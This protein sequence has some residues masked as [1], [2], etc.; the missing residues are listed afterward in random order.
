MSSSQA[1]GGGLYSVMGLNA[2]P[3]APCISAVCELIIDFIS[4]EP[5]C[6]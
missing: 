5:F 4:R 6:F 2:L 3:Q 1:C